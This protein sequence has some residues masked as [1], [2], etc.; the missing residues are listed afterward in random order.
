MAIYL[1]IAVL[2]FSRCV[3]KACK[4]DQRK[5]K[6]IWTE[7]A[8]NHPGVCVTRAASLTCTGAAATRA[9]GAEL[10][11]QQPWHQ[12][13]KHAGKGSINGSFTVSCAEG[14]FYPKNNWIIHAV[15]FGFWSR[16]WCLILNGSEY[17]WCYKFWLD[18]VLFL[19]W[20]DFFLDL[21]INEWHNIVG[22]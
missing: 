12:P 1:A 22:L 19:V 18:S 10:Q 13:G 7:D 14:G 3:G 16:D 8:T 11:L 15:G 2:A 9:P 4:N 5:P 6:R 20:R 21:N 17:R